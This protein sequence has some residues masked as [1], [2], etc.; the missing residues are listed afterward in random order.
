MDFVCVSGTEQSQHMLECDFHLHYSNGPHSGTPMSHCE[1]LYSRLH[2]PRSTPTVSPNSQ[3]FFGW[4]LF[5]VRLAGL[6]NIHTHRQAAGLTF[7]LKVPLEITDQFHF[8]SVRKR[9]A[10]FWA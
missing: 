1:S 2:L 9:L 5:V 6:F 7:L 10:I 4:S 3:G 8:R